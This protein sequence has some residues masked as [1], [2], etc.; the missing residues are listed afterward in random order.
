M[1]NEPLDLLLDHLLGGQEHILQ[2]LHQLCL[3]LGIGDSFPHLHDLH[4][5]LLV[6][7]LG[8]E[9]LFQSLASLIFINKESRNYARKN[10]ANEKKKKTCRSTLYG[11]SLCA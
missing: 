6:W 11:I 7:G 10:Y 9:K 8:K 5:G 1:F 2:D 4:D 3:E